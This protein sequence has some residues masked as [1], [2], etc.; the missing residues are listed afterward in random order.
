MGGRRFPARRAAALCCLTA[1]LSLAVGATPS[2]AA[3]ADPLPITPTQGLADTPVT[4]S[5]QFKVTSGCELAWDGIVVESDLTCGPE[6]E[7]ITA[8]AP[9]PP[10]THTVTVCQPSCAGAKATEEAQ[11]LVHN[12]VPGLTSQSSSSSP[13]NLVVVPDVRNH[14]VKAA[15]RIVA[16]A[17][18]VLA[19][20]PDARGRVIAQR[21]RPRTSVLRRSAVRVTL[22]VVVL[23]ARRLPPPSSGAPA[24][25][26]AL[27]VTVSIAALL[28]VA[29]VA[30]WL[31][32]RQRVRRRAR[33]PRPP[34]ARP[35]V[36][37][38]VLP[39]EVFVQVTGT[40]LA[41]TIEF[42]CVRESSVEVRS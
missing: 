25:P 13:P 3:A 33:L 41:P 40:P 39:A 22:A 23:P 17:G 42:R 2:R 15:R 28:A 26:A 27:I 5:P 10:G 7:P 21:P 30:V 38:A 8:A 36:V 20:A 19:V 32:R 18:L 24:V 37:R 6:S 34:H 16:A 1:V 11:F 9:G 31:I 35:R 29:I 12:T 14:S 4:V